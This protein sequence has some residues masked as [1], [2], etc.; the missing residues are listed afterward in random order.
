M[1][2]RLRFKL[3]MVLTVFAISFC[4]YSAQALELC[5]EGKKNLNGDYEV[6]QANGGLW[7]YMEKI[8]GL[9]EKSTLGLS[10]DG[11]L[12]RSL[13]IFETMCETDKKPDQG[14]Y[15]NIQK[16]ITSAQSIFNKI[17]G[18]TPVT[19]ILASI[20]ALSKNLDEL[21]KTMESK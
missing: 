14:V 21:L 20:E 6:L 12:Q 9:K 13:V 16:Q 5:K 17:P 1:I 18:K 11:K 7:G 19:D 8:Q 2:V 10:A 4:A 3:S 15:N